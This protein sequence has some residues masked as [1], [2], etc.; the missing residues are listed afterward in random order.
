MCACMDEYL[1]VVVRAFICVYGCVHIF[2]Q[3]SV[4]VSVTR[5]NIVT[6][7]WVVS[8]PHKKRPM[9]TSTYTYKSTFFLENSS[10]PLLGLRYLLL[11]QQ[12]TCFVQEKGLKVI[13]IY[14][15]IS[16]I[17]IY[18]SYLFIDMMYTCK[19]VYIH[20]SFFL[21]LCVCLCRESA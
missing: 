8:L 17:Y 12:T 1:C 14:I 18:D 11:F 9:Y 2:V 7:L 19:Y 3:A 10:Q 16:H 20:L 21:C 5:P 4:C 13:H 6:V 15:Y